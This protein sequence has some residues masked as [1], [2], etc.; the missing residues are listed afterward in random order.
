MKH[1]YMYKQAKMFNA[2]EGLN[3]VILRKVRFDVDFAE[4]V[5]FLLK[6]FVCLPKMIFLTKTLPKKVAKFTVHFHKK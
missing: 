6:T 2:P 5:L 1:F 3:Q 4:N